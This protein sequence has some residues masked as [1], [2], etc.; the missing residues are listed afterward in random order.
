MHIEVLN[1]NDPKIYNDPNKVMMLHP[2]DQL[3][4]LLHLVRTGQIVRGDEI[5]TLEL[6][7]LEAGYESDTDGHLN[8]AELASLDHLR[9]KMNDTAFKEAGKSLAEMMFGA[10]CAKKMRDLFTPDHLQPGPATP[11]R[12]AFAYLSKNLFDPD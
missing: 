12:Q 3:I 2:G 11:A 4:A 1:P 10:V 8:R 5:R 6:L 9:D 7:L